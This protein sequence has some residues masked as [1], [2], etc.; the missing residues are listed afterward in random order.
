MSSA[1]RSDEASLT[2]LPACHAIARL[3]QP[4]GKATVERVGRAAE[5]H[6]ADMLKGLDPA[7]RRRLAGGLA[8]LR[9]VF[10]NR[11]PSRPARRPRARTSG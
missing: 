3:G 6:L 1:E 5:A 2:L 9:R 11:A 4:L 8:V 7:S 10:A